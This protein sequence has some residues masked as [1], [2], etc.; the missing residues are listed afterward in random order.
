MAHAESHMQ[1]LVSAQQQYTNN[2]VWEDKHKHKVISLDYVIVLYVIDIQGNTKLF[3]AQLS[4]LK[5]GFSQY[6]FQTV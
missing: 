1:S 3:Y 4:F 5:L 6:V 2:T